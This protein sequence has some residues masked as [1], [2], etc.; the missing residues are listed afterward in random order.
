MSCFMPE[1]APAVKLQHETD[2][3]N[4]KKKV[5]DRPIEQQPPAIEPILA[6]RDKPRVQVEISHSRQGIDNPRIGVGEND[7]PAAKQAKQVCS[8]FKTQQSRRDQEN[9]AGPKEKIYPEGPHTRQAAQKRAYGQVKG[10]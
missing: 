4:D 5:G 1:R 3:R 9:G 8:S 6:P 7:Q 10:T 2:Q